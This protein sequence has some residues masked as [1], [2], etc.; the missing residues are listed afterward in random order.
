MIAPEV[1]FRLED[2]RDYAQ[3]ALDLLGDLTGDE[4]NASRETSYAISYA[5]QVVGEVASKIPRIMREAHP[6]IDWEPAVNLRHRLVHAYRAIL[7]PI[8]VKAIRDE[9]PGLIAE[10]GRILAGEDDPA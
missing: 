8:V 7:M 2:M 1:K 6:E 3:D 5:V 9:F 10:I 4:V